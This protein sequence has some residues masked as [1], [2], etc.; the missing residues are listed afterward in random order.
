M[1]G[2]KRPS[3]PLDKGRSP[4]QRSG[5]DRDPLPARAL[6]AS[7]PPPSRKAIAYGS[8]RAAISSLPL[9][10]G[11]MGRGLL[12]CDRLNQGDRGPPPPPP[13][14]APPPPREVRRAPPPAIA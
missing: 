1:P 11:G 2:R 3:P 5:G 7:R 14:T 9:K 12:E 6:R 4:A 10:R 8:G 13:R